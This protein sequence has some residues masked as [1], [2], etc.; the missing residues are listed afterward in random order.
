MISNRTKINT[1]LSVPIAALL[2]VATASAMADEQNT[3]YRE[4]C[5]SEV[6]QHYDA[7]T[8]VIVVSERITYSGRQVKLAARHDQDNTDIFTCWLPS[9][10]LA[11]E[12]SVRD[13]NIFAMRMQLPPTALHR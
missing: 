11:G 3:S 6:R 10:E 9:N 1:Y 4:T 13:L 12:G 2:L 7:N 8:E 5:K